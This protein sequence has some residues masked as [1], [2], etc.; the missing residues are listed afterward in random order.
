MPA[1]RPAGFRKSGDR[2]C[3]AEAVPGV[4]GA[5]VL[6]V[7]LSKHARVLRGPGG[8]DRGRHPGRHC[9]AVA[10]GRCPPERP[11]GDFADGDRRTGGAALA[12]G[13]RYQEG[14]AAAG[15]AAVAGEAALGGRGV[16][17]LEDILVVVGELFAGRDVPDRV[18]PDLRSLSHRIAIGLARVVDP[19]RGVAAHGGIDHDAVVD[20]EQEGMVPLAGDVGIARVGLGR[21]Q[22]LAGVFD[23]AGAGLDPAGGESAAALDGRL[24]DRERPAQH[25]P[26]LPTT[27][28]SDVCDPTRERWPRGD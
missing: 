27:V 2:V 18:D 10:P 9:A 5:E 19:P 14:A 21:R 1:H 26:N 6:P 20:G 23:E 28:D 12:P 16:A 15:S 3:A 11:R 4:Q 25:A 24:P 13:L 7:V 22:E 17:F 8:S